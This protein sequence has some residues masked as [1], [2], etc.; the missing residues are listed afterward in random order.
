MKPHVKTT[1]SIRTTW[2]RNATSIDMVKIM[3]SLHPRKIELQK[4][5]LVF[6]YIVD[7]ID[8][9]LGKDKFLDG[10]AEAVPRSLMDCCVA[11]LCQ[12]NII[13]SLTSCDATTT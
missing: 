2:C 1:L 12:S 7:G 11:M 9:G 3:T 10:S 8:V 13:T 5:M 6:T 4:P